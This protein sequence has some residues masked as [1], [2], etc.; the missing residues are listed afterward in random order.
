MDLLTV[1]PSKGAQVIY[2]GEMI[3]HIILLC[4][5]RLIGNLGVPKNLTIIQNKIILVSFSNP[6]EF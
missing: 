3:L 2:K 6:I 1:L 5:L 4:L